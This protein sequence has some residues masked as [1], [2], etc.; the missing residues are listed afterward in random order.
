MAA[1]H[2]SKDKIVGSFFNRASRRADISGIV[3]SD[4]F[5]ASDGRK[6]RRTA[7]KVKLQDDIQHKGWCFTS[8]GSSSLIEKDL[9][10]SNSATLSVSSI[11]IGLFHFLV[12]IPDTLI[13]QGNQKLFGRGNDIGIQIR[14]S[15]SGLSI[16]VRGNYRP[17]WL[18][19]FEDE[20]YKLNDWNWISVYRDGSNTTDTTLSSANEAVKV[21]INGTQLNNLTTANPG[22]QSSGNSATEWALLDWS[23]V[24]SGFNPANYVSLFTFFGMVY[25]FDQGPD[26]SVVTDIHNS[27]FSLKNIETLYVPNADIGCYCGGGAQNTICFGRLIESPNDGDIY[28]NND[29]PGFINDT[30]VTPYSIVNELGHNVAGPSYFKNAYVADDHAQRTPAWASFMGDADFSI[31]FK[32]NISTLQDSNVYDIM[33][34]SGGI[35]SGVYILIT[36]GKIQVTVTKS[37]S[38]TRT[39]TSRD[40]RDGLDHD[41]LV[42]YEASSLLCRIYVDGLEEP[43]GAQVTGVGGNQYN[44]NTSWVIGKYAA[45]A[46]DRNFTGYI[47]AVS[48]YNSAL[49]PATLK[50]GNPVAQPQ[51]ASDGTVTD[52]VGGSTWTSNNLDDTDL[53]PTDS[54][55]LYD[56]L[57]H[58]VLDYPGRLAPRLQLVNAPCVSLN[59]VDQGA[60]LDTFDLP[61]FN[62]FKLSGTFYFKSTGGTAIALSN[63]LSNYFGLTLLVGNELRVYRRDTISTQ[64]NTDTGILIALNQWYH[65]EIDFISDTEL[66]ITVNNEL[67][68]FT[69]LSPVDINNLSGAAGKFNVGVL[70]ST[71]FAN[72][73]FYDVKLKLDDTVQIHWAA[74]EDNGSTIFD[75]SGN[76][77]HGKVVNAVLPDI[78]GTQDLFHYNFYEG[79]IKSLKDM[80]GVE[81]FFDFTDINAYTFNESGQITNIRDAAGNYLLTNTH[82]DARFE[83]GAL[84]LGGNYLWMEDGHFL[85]GLNSFDVFIRAEFISS[86]DSGTD[87]LVVSNDTNVEHWRIGKHPIVADTRVFYNAASETPAYSTSQGT[88]LSEIVFDQVLNYNIKHDGANLYTGRDAN[89]LTDHGPAIKPADNPLL[90]SIN[91][92]IEGS[93]QYLIVCNR[94]VTDQERFFINAFMES[95]LA[96]AGA[97]NGVVDQ[98]GYKETNQFNGTSDVQFPDIPEIPKSLRAKAF[99][100][101]EIDA[102]GAMGFR[103]AGNTHDLLVLSEPL[104]D[105]SLTRYLNLQGY[106]PETNSYKD[107]TGAHTIPASVSDKN[108]FELDVFIKALKKGLNL[109]L[110]Q[111]NLNSVFDY[112]FIF[113]LDLPTEL[114]QDTNSAYTDIPRYWAIDI[115]NNRVIR[116][117]ADKPFVNF[118][119]NK[120]I[121]TTTGDDRL[122]IAGYDLDEITNSSVVHHKNIE[123]GTFFIENTVGVSNDYIASG[124]NNSD[125]VGLYMGVQWQSANSGR[126]AARL[127]SSSLRYSDYFNP[128]EK[129]ISCKRIGDA[130]YYFVDGELAN[131]HPSITEGAIPTEQYFA[132]M[133]SAWSGGGFSSTSCRNPIAINYMAN[134]EKL[135]TKV[136][137]ECF[138][139]YY[140]RRNLSS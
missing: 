57:G 41:I 136:L 60:T 56:T 101:N 131:T 28:V 40:L 127:N 116:E 115:A 140:N 22:T 61:I 104:D 13:D 9:I 139:D 106:E 99:T 72:V 92:G 31:A 63:G 97:V 95:G 48:F 105:L 83:N 65:I 15:S 58:K 123:M 29:L 130:Y 118:L 98:R 108:I 87:F 78:W 132:F 26:L 1:N 107:F 114:Y 55:G 88:L 122:S 94:N 74:S 120:G 2:I 77:H 79:F 70:Q 85:S 32:V 20:S 23:H 129:L 10:G 24:D 112:L 14:T 6:G 52:L 11:S 59:G 66:S 84:T 19:E 76:H 16:R 133:S 134:A 121:S 12:Y 128:V 44:P 64:I 49:T 3:P 45:S 7:E 110:G 137:S 39:V 42:V 21:W 37:I 4:H 125:A 68:S 18:Y 111:R 8:N 119:T 124:Y 5:V 102:V 50:T 75:V 62:S 135:N 103:L 71:D 67:H 138:K 109:D 89:V 53:V 126:I 27:S 80:N 33:S 51:V 17:Y 91:F 86:P 30:I 82:A 34:N 90:T 54:T 35:S 117:R 69:G 43:Y 93:Q 100:P 38:N 73:N 96:P 113:A 36:G 47:K 25:P 46:G 81:A